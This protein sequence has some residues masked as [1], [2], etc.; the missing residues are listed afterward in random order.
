M[1]GNIF[2]HGPGPV[3]LHLPA[4]ALQVH[5]EGSQDGQHGPHQCRLE[6]GEADIQEPGQG[7]RP[8]CGLGGILCKI[9]RTIQHQFQGCGLKN[10]F[11]NVDY[12]TDKISIMQLVQ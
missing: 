9:S 4:G 12:V 5:R 7:R 11:F 2:Q 8:P 10:I 6:G 1:E 3:W